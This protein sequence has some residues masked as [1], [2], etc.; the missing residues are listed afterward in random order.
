MMYGYDKADAVKWI[1]A[2]VDRKEHKSL[3]FVLEQLLDELQKVIP[4]LGVEL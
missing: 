4:I 2:H 1:A 3:V